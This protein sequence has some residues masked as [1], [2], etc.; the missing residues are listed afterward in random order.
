M[1]KFHDAE[2]IESLIYQIVGAGSMCWEHVEHAGIFDDKKA[3]E[4]AIHGIDRLREMIGD[5][6]MHQLNIERF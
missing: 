5:N 2:T 3:R 6:L 4:T 1:N